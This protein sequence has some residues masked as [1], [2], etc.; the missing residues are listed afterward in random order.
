M[1]LPTATLRLPAMGVLL[2]ASLLGATPAV[3]AS[4]V[5]W[6]TWIS[7][8]HTNGGNWGGYGATGHTFTTIT[9]SWKEPKAVCQADHDLYAP[10]LGIDGYGDST[11][12]QTGV[13]TSCQSGSPVD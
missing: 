6:N 10:W 8:P 3:A 12:E 1:R 9:G 5:S 2:A 11:V 7:G 4:P 13:Q